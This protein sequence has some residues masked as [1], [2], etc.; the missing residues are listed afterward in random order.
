VADSAGASNGLL[1]RGPQLFVLDGV[2]APGK[3][4]A[5]VE[6]ALREQVV[7]VA[8]EGISAAELERVKT[9]WIASEV[10]KRD[11]LFNQA[12]EIGTYWVLGLPLDT[13]DQL[14]ARLRGVTAAQ[15]QSVAA[16]YFGDE[17]LTVAHLL[18]QPPDP[19]RPRR[20]PAAGSRH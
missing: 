7:R 19:N 13:N 6:A 8:R 2:P 5:Q 9:Q 4:A 17:Q 15:V 12:R 10:Y 16:R 14:L 11:S 18:P 20:Q 3:T 1:G